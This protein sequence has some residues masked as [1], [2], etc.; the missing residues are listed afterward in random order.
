MAARG[1]PRRWGACDEKAM[2]PFLR[3][4]IP[5]TP[6]PHASARP[7]RRAQQQKND[8]SHSRPPHNPKKPGPPI[9]PTRPLLE[10]PIKTTKRP[11]REP[12]VQSRAA[13]SRA[14]AAATKRQNRQ[15]RHQEAAH[16]L[17]R[18]GRRR[19]HG[20]PEPAPTEHDARA[21]TQDSSPADAVPPQVVR[22]PDHGRQFE[23]RLRVQL[24]EGRGPETRSSETATAAVVKALILAR[25]VAL[26]D[27]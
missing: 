18:D 15:P 27:K 8:A 20:G 9:R 16:N 19:A 3:A 7:L 25:L 23:R 12:T 14:C 17:I 2:V 24:T 5:P 13:G 21:S 6:L 11:I 22:F 26:Y 4:R 10:G 1:N